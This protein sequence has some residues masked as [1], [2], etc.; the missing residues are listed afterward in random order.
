MS[1][2]GDSENIGLR[3]K[4]TIR[5]WLTGKQ[6]M[7]FVAAVPEAMNRDIILHYDPYQDLITKIAGRQNGL[8]HLANEI[9]AIG[10]DQLLVWIRHF[11]Q[12]ING[13]HV[14]LEHEEWKLLRQAILE[15]RPLLEVVIEELERLQQRQPRIIRQVAVTYDMVHSAFEIFNPQGVRGL[16][17]K[18]DEWRKGIVDAKD[19]KSLSF[20]T[21][22][23]NLVDI[24]HTENDS[25][26]DDEIDNAYIESIG[27]VEHIMR[28]LVKP[29]PGFTADDVAM[30]EIT[31]VFKMKFK[32]KETGRNLVVLLGHRKGHSQSDLLGS[33]LIYQ[34]H[35]YK[36]LIFVQYKNLEEDKTW[37]LSTTDKQL[38]TLLGTCYAQGHCHNCLGKGHYRPSSEMRLHDCPVF[39]RSDSNLSRGWLKG[40]MLND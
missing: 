21:S 15:V 5:V 26:I 31:K 40:I 8:A 9:M 10:R 1:S 28:D 14:I 4:D 6:S 25:K 23:Q 20:E 24:F 17:E 18:L 32:D 38:E 37:S 19:P 34:H 2:L 36:S 29:I 3:P 27:E 7:N 30:A 11:D 13:R 35:Q 16:N 33:D 39:Y 22:A 12:V